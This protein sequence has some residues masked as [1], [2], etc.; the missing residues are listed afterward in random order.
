MVLN[1][2]EEDDTADRSGGYVP[3]LFSF[4]E[5]NPWSPW[6]NKIVHGCLFTYIYGGSR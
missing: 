6:P 3:W 4:T 2:E 1:L 5:N